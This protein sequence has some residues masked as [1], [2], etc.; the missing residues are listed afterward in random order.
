MKAIETRG[1]TSKIYQNLYNA[2]V[3]QAWKLIA[4][5]KVKKDAEAVNRNFRAGFG[6]DKKVV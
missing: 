3:N 1:H 2:D 6:A 4:A 5:T